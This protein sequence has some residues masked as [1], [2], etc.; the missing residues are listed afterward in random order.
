MKYT[1]QRSLLRPPCWGSPPAV[2]VTMQRTMPQGS[3]GKGDGNITLWLAGSDTPQ[4]LR[5]YLVTTFEKEN[6]GS[7]L[8]IEEQARDL[9]TKLT[10]A[11]PDEKNN[12]VLWKSATLSPDVYHGWRLPR[13]Q[14]D[15]R[16]VG[17]EDLPSPSLRSA[18]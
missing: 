16:G 2:L 17:R 12:Y 5:D 9:V 15:L 14:P 11:L 10:T 13:S 6:P 3:T 7:T 1:S 18:C 8:T 4:E